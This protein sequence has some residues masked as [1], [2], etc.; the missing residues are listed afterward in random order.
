MI[1]LSSEEM[2]QLQKVIDFS[3]RQ[4]IA[5]VRDGLINKTDSIWWR[6]SNGP[7]KKTAAEHWDNIKEFPEFYQ[8]A[9]PKTQLIYID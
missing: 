3:A 7:I 9:E 6:N 5:R 2:D 4:D 8:I 1:K